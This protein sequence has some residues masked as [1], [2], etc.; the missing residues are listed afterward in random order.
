MKH[1]AIYLMFTIP[2]IMNGA[3]VLDVESSSGEIHTKPLVEVATIDEGFCSSSYKSKC[4]A[5]DPV[6]DPAYN[7]R[8]LIKQTILL[9]EHL[10]KYIC[11]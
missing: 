5:I 2:L 6:S 3:A 4:G 8:N 11:S 9:E 1:F 10:G 7:M